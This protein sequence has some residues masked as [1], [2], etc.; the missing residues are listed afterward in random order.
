[1]RDERRGIGRKEERG[2]GMRVEELREGGRT[3]VR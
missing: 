1:M 3:G 2:I